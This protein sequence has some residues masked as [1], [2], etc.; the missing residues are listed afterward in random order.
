MVNINHV[1][2]LKL[3]SDM[4][5]SALKPGLHCPD[6]GARWSPMAKSAGF[7]STS[8]NSE[9]NSVNNVLF[10]GTSSDIGNEGPMFG[11]HRQ[12]ARKERTCLLILGMSGVNRFMGV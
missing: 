6:C 5:F 10:P 12:T 1:Q 9:G 7:V 2:Q 3:D 4:I 8:A 11:Q